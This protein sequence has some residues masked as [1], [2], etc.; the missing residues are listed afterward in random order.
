MAINIA[1]N[2]AKTLPITSLY[3]SPPSVIKEFDMKMMTPE[4][5]RQIAATS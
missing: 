1:L 2:K 3:I 4:K 5:V